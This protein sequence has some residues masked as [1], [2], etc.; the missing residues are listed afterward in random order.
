MAS[1]F[2][3]YLFILYFTFFSVSPTFASSISPLT[4]PTGGQ[5][6]SGN[7]NINQSAPGKLVV[8]QTTNQG[9]INWQSFNVGVDAAVHFNTPNASA[10]T[11]NNIS[12]GT[13]TILGSIFSNGRLFF[14]N[15]SGIIFKP[16]S[17]VKAEGLVAS[18]MKISNQDFLSNNFNFTN[19][20]I[21]SLQNEGNLEAQ[22]VALIAPQVLNKGT[23]TTNVATM[24]AAGDDVKLSISDSNRLSVNINPAKIKTLSSNEGVIKSENGTVSIQANAAQE[25]V[26]QTINAPRSA[27]SLI[28]ENG[29]IKLVSNSGSIKAKSI[30]LSAGPLGGT[31]VTGTIDASSN[32]KG[33]DIE[34]TGQEIQ[35]KSNS[36]LLATGETGGG[37]ILVGGD[38]QG[39]NGIL[40]ATYT[41]VEKDTLIDASSKGIGDGGKIVVWSDIHNSN[42]KTSVNG[43]LFSKANIGDGGKIET[44]GSLINTESATIN[45]SSVTS[46]GGLWLIDPYD[47]T[48]T[49]SAANQ[50]TN[51]LNSGTNVSIQTS[52][53]NTSYGS[54]GSNSGNGDITINSNI[55]TTSSSATSS[56]LTL[57]AARNIVSNSGVTIGN[58]GLHSLSLIFNAGGNIT[59]NGEVNVAGTI[60]LTTTS[61]SGGTITE[62][63]SYTGAQQTWSVPTAVTS[64]T[65]DGYGAAGGHGASDQRGI[66]GKGGR[67]IATST[68]TPGEN[69][70][71]YVGG[72]GGNTT[73]NPGTGYDSVNNPYSAGDA[74]PGFNGG[75]SPGSESGGAGGGAT[76]IRQG[77]N[78][79]TN[80]IFVAGGGGGG[81]NQ[82]R[83]SE[84]GGNGGDGGGLI[85]GSGT[86]GANGHGKG[87]NGG[88]QS[89]GGIAVSNNGS[90][91]SLGVGGK[92]G[93]SGRTGGGG[94]GG[95]YGGSGGGD[96]SSGNAAGGGGGGGSSYSSG[97][98][99]TNTQGYSLATGNG[100]LSITYTSST[101]GNILINQSLRATGGLT[102]NT[103]G[104]LTNNSQISYQGI[105]ANNIVNS[106]VL[107]YN[108]LVDKTFSGI[109]SG[110]GSL[111]KSGS[112][113]LT[114]SGANTYSGGT[115]L[116]A[117]QIS[118]G[119]NQNSSSTS[120]ALGTGTLTMNGGTLGNT[121]SYGT[122]FNNILVNTGVTSTLKETAGS[123]LYLA[124]NITGSGTLQVDNTSG[125]TVALA[126]DNSGFTGTYIHPSS[127]VGNTGFYSST[128]GSPNA[129]W[130]LSGGRFVNEVSGG[131][132]SLGSLSS[133]ASSGFLLGSS[134][135]N[136][137]A[138]YTIGG[139]NL[140]STFTGKIE[141]NYPNASNN[142]LSIAKSGSGR[143]T[144]T[145]TNTYT[146]TTT[147]NAGTLSLPVP[148]SN[149][150]QHYS[151]SYSI[152]S[153]ATLEYNTPSG[154]VNYS[155]GNVTYSGQGTIKKVGAGQIQWGQMAATF[156]LGSGSLIDVQEGT[157]VG[158]SSGN[159]V[160]TNNRSNLNIASG[161]NFYGVEA[162]III[163]AL[164]GAGTIH[165]GLQDWP[166]ASVTMGVNNTQAGTYNSSGSA[167][168][169]GSIK[170]S[171]NSSS[172][173]GKIIKSGSGTQILSG[174]NTYTGT[175]TV[176]AGTLSVTGTLGSGTYAGNIANAGTLAMGSSSNQ[177]LSGVVSGTGALTK[178]GSGVLTLSG[179]NT[180]T[181][182]TTISAGTLS[183]S[184]LADTT[185]LSVASGATY[186]LDQNDTVASITGA[187]NINLQDKTLTSAGASDTN[188]SGIILGTGG[189]TIT[190]SN[191][192]T[193]SGA[194]TYSGTTHI[195]G[196]GLILANSNALASN[197]IQST[198][199]RLKTTERISNLTVTG[200]V[201]LIGDI[202]TT[203]AQTFSNNVTIGAG[204]SANPLTISSQNSDIT[205]SGTV[206]TGSGAKAEQRSLTVNAGTGNVT[207]NDRVGYDFNGITFNPQ[208]TADS[209][210]ALSVTGGNIILKGDVMTFETQTYNG[211][212]KIGGT[213]S[214]GTTR[215]LLSMDPKITFNG[216]VDDT[217]ANT[218]TLV[219]KA[220]QIRDNVL[221]SGAPEV[222]FNRPVSSVT[223]LQGYQGSTGYQI[224]SNEFG[225]IDGSASFGSVKLPPSP[226]SPSSGDSSQSEQRNIERKI[227]SLKTNIAKSSSNTKTGMTLSQMF[228]SFKP[229][230]GTSF[231]K[232]IEIVYP[233]SLNFGAGKIT[234]TLPADAKSNNTL[235]QSQPNNQPN[236]TKPN[237]NQPNQKQN[238]S[239]EIN[240]DDRL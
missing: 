38:W 101:T 155:A 22:Y 15:P 167:T 153:G 231:V 165:T 151:P 71:I 232:S 163:D 121:S 91:G 189:L 50:I 64:I 218:H 188:F 221:A 21:A 152:S 154:T 78:S 169:S 33:G 53:N 210:Y 60:G 143:L 17:Q 13:S 136:K 25:L 182:A 59:L 54:G 131:N 230:A 2:L 205:F 51:T 49:T 178:S 137:N 229:Q 185:A 28:S 96:G 200:A 148:S 238:S 215:T 45:A 7:I 6:A 181:G 126:G 94:G 142:V 87:G 12:G 226:S 44:S 43:Q 173:P 194:N 195:N 98:I 10:G 40:Q 37:N 112:G 129:S 85:G 47:Y 166:N 16:G 159:E 175:T 172:H 186:K 125:W 20:Q 62:S 79:L 139:K 207:F 80:R 211:A 5:V 48:I 135:G 187:G 76:D 147:I 149:S 111:S 179:T 228:S 114:L 8:N 118:L 204:S 197:S 66:G 109:I 162:P 104:S 95:Y 223:K 196:G 220:V 127:T 171:D 191:N 116:T 77:G 201:N 145:G 106:G 39:S 233:D 42:S 158:G 34:I 32:A 41:T 57:D 86:N 237:N 203:G 61:Y 216:T 52:T 140:D 11:L 174:D 18:A 146:G 72:K 14:A 219:A 224:V 31:E 89:T 144:L 122:I 83:N 236:Q 73:A 130:E 36:K 225:S 63:F 88:T 103:Q 198:S 150:A 120:G 170:N 93:T 19:N 108:T 192:L 156:A 102:V 208:L 177:T 97:R 128:A 56:T 180:Y 227:S 110:T 75:G 164:T 9:I 123:N 161:A 55:S 27:D 234:K 235:N 176:S 213:G 90:A 81:G 82:R 124:G 92:G 4:V 26:D 29:V 107:T 70:Y 141:N 217:Q 67:L 1:K 199:G 100:L 133:N 119:A 184:S 209:P 240:D 3:K 239:G 117:G 68:V 132:I 115:T 74:L 134:G 202:A 183:A 168:F 193:L 222:N 105:A 58:N 23:I 84:G 24:I 65:I 160:W 138:S 113:I 190:G 214:N 46:K 212:V 206:K 35:V 30:N 69:L 157:F 99:T